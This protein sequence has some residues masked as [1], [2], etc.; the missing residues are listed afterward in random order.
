MEYKSYPQQSPE[1]SAPAELLSGAHMD[2]HRADP[3]LKSLEEVRQEAADAYESPKKEET[4]RLPH[5]VIH[6]VG[7]GIIRL[8]VIT[9]QETVSQA[10]RSWNDFEVTR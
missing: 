3:R 10:D 2:F 8:R 7:R 9:Q 6:N 5:E 4:E 1:H